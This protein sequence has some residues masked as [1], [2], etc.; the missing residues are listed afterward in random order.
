[1]THVSNSL[2]IA[3]P[4]STYPHRSCDDMSF[5]QTLSGFRKKAKEKLSKIGSKRDEQPAGDGSGGFDRS[6]SSLQP[7]K[8]DWGRTTSSAVKLFLHTVERASDAFPPLKSVAGGLCAILEN[9][10]VHC[11]IVRLVCNTHSF[12]SERRSTNRR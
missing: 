4:P 3:V 9:C 10:E 11:A 7:D 5:R 6:S 12:P 1:M 8:P 2:P